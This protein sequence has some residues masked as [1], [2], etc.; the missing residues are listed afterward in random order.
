VHLFDAKSGQAVARP[1]S[2]ASRP[3]AGS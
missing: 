2:L 3:L 1:E